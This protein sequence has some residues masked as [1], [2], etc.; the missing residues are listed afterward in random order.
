MLLNFKKTA[1][2]LVNNLEE[3]ANPVLLYYKFNP[4]YALEF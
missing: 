2:A 3:D 4:D 1:I